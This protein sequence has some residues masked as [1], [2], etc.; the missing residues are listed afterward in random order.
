MKK[1]FVVATI[2]LMILGIQHA[3]DLDSLFVSK[4]V[5]SEVE[6]AEQQP[7]ENPQAE[8]VMVCDA[9]ACGGDLFG[10]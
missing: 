4:S 3:Y 6:V 9:L 2:V 7:V 1:Y 5:A 10:F 8:E